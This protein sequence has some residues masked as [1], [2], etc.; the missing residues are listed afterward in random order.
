MSRKEEV[1]QKLL[2]K[3]L[4]SKRIQPVIKEHDIIYLTSVKY[5]LSPNKSGSLV[6][7]L[8]APETANTRQ[9]YSGGG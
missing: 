9:E 2:R 1:P 3:S 4:H 8:G 7:L 6:W 5:T